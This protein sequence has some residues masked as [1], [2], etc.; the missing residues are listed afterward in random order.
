MSKVKKTK[1]KKKEFSG[2]TMVNARGKEVPVEMVRRDT[3]R[4]DKT[5]KKIFRMVGNMSN[6][7]T[8][9]K[10]GVFT[11][12]NRF[13]DY[14]KKVNKAE[15]VEVNNLTLSTYD[16]L[17]KVSIKSSDIIKLNDTRQL[18]EAKIKN[19]LN[20]WGADAHPWLKTIVE[21]LFK[22]N[23]EGLVNV[24]ELRALKQYD[25]QDSEWKEAMELLTRAEEIVGKRQYI[26]FQIREDINSKWQTVDLNF[27]SMEANNA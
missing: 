10:Q 1:K 20:R 22:T 12:V 7:M 14:W 15:G 18:A 4:E 11:E 2:A 26:N 13:M 17:M 25:I 23:K 5:V 6:K 9:T 8:C 3:L 24:Q 21:E 27:S 16:G 19:C